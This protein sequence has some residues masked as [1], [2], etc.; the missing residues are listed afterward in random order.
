MRS[1]ASVKAA[2]LVRWLGKRPSSVAARDIRFEVAQ[3]LCQMVVNELS[4]NGRQ[5]RA[6][7]REAS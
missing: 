4:T 6:A 1:Y 3:C 7:A 5:F 2:I